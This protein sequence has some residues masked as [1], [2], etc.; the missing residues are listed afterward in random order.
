MK[1]KLAAQTFSSSVADALEFCR[2]GLRLEQFQNGQGT[3]NFLRLLDGLFDV[4]NSRS[5]FGHGMKGAVKPEA[6]E[7]TNSF[8]NKAYSYIASLTDIAGNAVYTTLGRTPFIGFIMADIKSVQALN[9][10]CVGQDKPLQYLLMHKLSQDHLELFFSAVRWAGGFN[11]N[12]SGRQFMAMYK[13]LM[14][15]HD[16]QIVT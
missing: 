3:V 7:A 15:C 2:D 10:Q 12:P 13:Q 9:K 8:L 11:S 5:K 4:L 16:V 1:V 14:M 6:D